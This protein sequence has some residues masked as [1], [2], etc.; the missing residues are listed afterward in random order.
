MCGNY[1]Y[2]DS[3]L[4]APDYRIKMKNKTWG[5]RLQINDVYSTDSGSY[6]CEV[7]EG[8]TEVAK[9]EAQLHVSFSEFI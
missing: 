8:S 6:R 9:L 5:T 7:T 4:L 1:R 2:K 3:V